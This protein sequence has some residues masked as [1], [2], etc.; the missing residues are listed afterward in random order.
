K[1]HPSQIWPSRYFDN[2]GSLI[3]RKPRNKS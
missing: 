2:T 3:E 1:L